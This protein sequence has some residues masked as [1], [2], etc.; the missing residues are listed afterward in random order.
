MAAAAML[1]F[2]KIV[3]L[4]PIPYVTVPNFIKIGH[5]VAEIW[6]FYGF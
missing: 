6:R 3:I 2:K 1:I 4:R 5:V